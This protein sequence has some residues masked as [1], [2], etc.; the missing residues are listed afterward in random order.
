MCWSYEE[1][2]RVVKC[3]NGVDNG[4]PTKSGKLS[5]FNVSGRNLYLS[6]LPK[7][8]VKEVFLGLRNPLLG[9]KSGDY[10]RIR[11][12]IPTA[13]F[14]R[15]SIGKTDWMMGYEEMS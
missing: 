5:I 6:A 1:E 15:C 10:D 14:Y 2:V 8:T 4:K 7:G 13:H 9:E 11:N 12:L 3:I